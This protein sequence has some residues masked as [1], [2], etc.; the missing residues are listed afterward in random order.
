MRAVGAFLSTSFASTMY[1]CK[2]RPKVFEG[3]QPSRLVLSRFI[4]LHRINDAHCN[5]ACL[6]MEK[7]WRHRNAKKRDDVRREAPPCCTQYDLA[8]TQSP[9]TL[10]RSQAPADL[11]VQY[12]KTRF[13]CPSSACF[14]SSLLCLIV[15]NFNKDSVAEADKKKT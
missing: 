14:H 11:A 8:A 7:Y 10:S 13:Y 1:I 9:L 4:P 12:F 5:G 3:R 2:A 15:L 6:I